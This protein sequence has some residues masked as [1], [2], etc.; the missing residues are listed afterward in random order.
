MIKL[1]KLRAFLKNQNDIFKNLIL[2]ENEKNYGYAKGNNIGILKSKGEIIGVFNNDIELGDKVI[3]ECV[4]LL[5]NN[6]EIGIC[7]PKIVYF[8]NPEIIWYAGGIINPRF[9]LVA[10]H[11]GAF[12]KDEGQYDEIMETDYSNG[13]CMFIKR[14]ALK[15]SGLFDQF[16]FL[17]YEETDLNL[18]IKKHGYKVYYLGNVKVLHKIKITENKP[19]QIYFYTRNRMIFSIKHFNSINIIKFF[20][21]QI[22]TSVFEI[23]KYL[24]DYKKIRIF[25][26][27]LI[28]G[29][30]YGFEK[31]NKSKYLRLSN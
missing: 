5:Q 15:E 22:K 26:R 14:K 10:K 20:L 27:G 29:I 25:T 18:R 4:S 23:M 11:R 21:S 3:E 16:Y 12:E 19:F 2:I 31:K 6:R 7:C 8:S 1:Q 9:K 17:Y 30:Q 24:P 13:S 28:N